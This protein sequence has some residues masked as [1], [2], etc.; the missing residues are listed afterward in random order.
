MVNYLGISGMFFK[1]IHLSIEDKILVSTSMLTSV[2]VKPGRKSNMWMDAL[3]LL[4]SSQ[5]ILLFQI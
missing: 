2:K 5:H 4:C 3:V 1:S